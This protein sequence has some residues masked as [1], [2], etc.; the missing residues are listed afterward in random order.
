MAAIRTGTGVFWEWIEALAHHGSLSPD[1]EITLRKHG[2]V[3]GGV[4]LPLLT[5][6]LVSDLRRS[7]SLG[8]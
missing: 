1:L 5:T 8:Q 4:S 7:G 2:W 3:P 6:A